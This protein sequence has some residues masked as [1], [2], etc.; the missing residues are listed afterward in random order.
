MVGASARS[1]SRHAHCPQLENIGQFTKIHYNRKRSRSCLAF[2]LRLTLSYRP[3]APKAESTLYKT[4]TQEV[5]G[6]SFCNMRCF[7]ETDGDPTTVMTRLITHLLKRWQLFGSRLRKSSQRQKVDWQLRFSLQNDIC[8]GSG[9]GGRK[10]KTVPRESRGKD[11]VR[12]IGMPVDNK[13]LV[14]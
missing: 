7:S 12:P 2:L 5:G 10:F 14:R 4:T 9:Q 6:L 11:H 13:M 8:K 1:A 3:R